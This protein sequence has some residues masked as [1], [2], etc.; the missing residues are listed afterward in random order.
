MTANN[1][2]NTPTTKKASPA[3]KKPSRATTNKQKLKL[4]HVYRMLME[5]TDAEHG[6]SMTQI[7]SK[8]ADVNIQAER[9]SIYHDF[10][11]LRKFGLEIITIPHAPV[12]YAVVKDK[13]SLSEVALLMDAVQGSKFL[14]ENKCNHL[15]K[16]V[17]NMASEPQRALLDKRVHVEGRIKSQ[18]D[19]VF[20]NVDTIHEAMRLKR[21]VQFMYFKYGP[22][23]ERHATR[24]EKYVHTPVKVVFTEGFYYVVTWSDHNE[25]FVTFR[26]D[27]MHLV[28]VSEQSATRNAHIANYSFDTFEYKT[29]GMFGGKP[30]NVTLHCAGSGIDVV[31]DTFGREAL[32]PTNVMLANNNETSNSKNN[33][34]NSRK[35]SS[36]AL[37]SCDVHVPVTVSPQ[38]YG[39]LAGL[40][41]VVELVAPQ[42]AV[43]AYKQWLRNVLKGE[44]M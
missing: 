15:A 41:G 6:L 33:S 40:S 12:E 19:S 42:S 3:N 28:Q 7:L 4:L 38:F 26:V 25:S 11:A 29:F 17:K 5:Q 14:T 36:N 10:E 21:K 32:K 31:V 13:P 23:L 16:L 34:K 39:W 30:E 20:H 37:G 24:T 2:S 44:E 9:K 43:S 27:R 8:L 22:D 18:N 1:L 35:N